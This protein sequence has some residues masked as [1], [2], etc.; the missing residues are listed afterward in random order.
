M[1]IVCVGECTIDRYLD[2]GIAHVGGISLNFAVNAR[3]CGA[4]QVALVSCVGDDAGGRLVLEKLAREQIDASCVAR[5]HGLTASQNIRMAPVGER[6]F[7]P[8]G[9]QAGVLHEWSLGE[10]ELAFLAGFDVLAVPVFAQIEHITWAALQAP[11]FGGRRVA[12]FLD[13]A[14]RGPDLPELDR[15]FERLDIA[16]FS[17]DAAFVEELRPQSRAGRTVIVVTHGAAGSTA[18]IGGE[19]LT[20]P[21]VAVATPIDTTGCGDA[22]QAAFTVRYLRTGDVRAALEAGAEQAALA[23]RHYGATE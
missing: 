6:I 3:R 2:L 5:L 21:A 18:L 15:Y 9:Y 14:D 17:G 10:V 20:H 11:G 12:D 1:N 19:P 16:F 7:P 4:R 13:G 8:G 22:F 23:T